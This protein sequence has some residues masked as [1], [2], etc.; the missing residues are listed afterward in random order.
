MPIDEEVVSKRTSTENNLSML[1]IKVGFPLKSLNTKH[2]REHVNKR[3]SI[4][5]LDQIG[6]RSFQVSCRH[7]TEMLPSTFEGTKGKVCQTIDE[8]VKRNKSVNLVYR[9]PIQVTQDMTELQTT[10]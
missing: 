9:K 5:M 10:D 4:K 7:V 8:A 6:V 3:Q 2:V 1:Q